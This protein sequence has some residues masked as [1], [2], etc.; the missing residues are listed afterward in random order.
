MNRQGIEWVEK[1]VGQ[2]LATRQKGNP[3]STVILEFLL[4]Y[5]TKPEHQLRVRE[6]ICQDSSQ[7]LF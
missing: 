6:E 5:L 7:D 4:Y 2:K 3:G 1:K